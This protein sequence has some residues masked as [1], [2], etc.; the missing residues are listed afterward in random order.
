RFALIR[1]AGHMPPIER[2]E[3]LAGL[4]AGFLDEIDAA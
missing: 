1:G 2:P 3:A 4:I